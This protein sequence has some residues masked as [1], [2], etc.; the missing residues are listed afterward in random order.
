MS[1]PDEG[2][3]ISN[4]THPALGRRCLK[5]I[6]LAVTLCVVAGTVLVIQHAKAYGIMAR[7]HHGLIVC[8]TNT[9]PDAFAPPAG[10]GQPSMLRLEVSAKPDGQIIVGSDVGALGAST[11]ASV[12]NSAYRAHTL[13]MLDLNQT[14]PK[15]VTELIR[16]AHMRDRVIL[17]A[18]DRKSQEDA[19]RADRKVMIA[20]P[21]HSEREAYAAHKMAG[22]HPYAAY[23][24]PTAAPSLFALAHR[25][26]EAI[27]TENPVTS[28]GPET[29][30]LAERPVDIV[31]TQ[32]PAHMANVPHRNSNS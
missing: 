20:F 32:D 15:S 4:R 7:I 17:I 28:Q 22:R 11:L 21:I 23:L 8:T 31:V 24:S 26:A 12:L 10:D 1:H 29:D 16:T 2:A 25:D 19:L 14:D 30:F 3:D 9:G 27:I 6:A 18:S 5:K 13:L